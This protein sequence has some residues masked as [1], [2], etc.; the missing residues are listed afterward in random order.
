MKV[1]AIIAADFQGVPLR[2][3]GHPVSY[4]SP[5]PPAGGPPRREGDEAGDTMP[6]T[7][8]Q[9]KWVEV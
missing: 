6:T 1:D 2:A 9:M 3:Q 8:G 7:W 5:A 4:G